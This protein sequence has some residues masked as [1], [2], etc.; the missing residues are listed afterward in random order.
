[1]HK[2]E[3]AVLEALEALGGDA[4]RASITRKAAQSDQFTAAE[5]RTPAPPSKGQYVTYLSYR[6]SW[7]FTALKNQGLVENYRPGRWRLSA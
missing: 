4:D 6:L 3:R 5:S 7:S 2:C 1:M